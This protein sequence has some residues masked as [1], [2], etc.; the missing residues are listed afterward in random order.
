MRR[1]EQEIKDRARVDSIIRGSRVCRLGLSDQGQPYVVPLCFGYD[2]KA[3][4][5]HCAKEG[6]QLD[7]LRRNDKVC[8]EFDIVEGMVEADHGCNWGIRYQSIIGFGV[9]HLVDDATDKQKALT[10]LMAA[11]QGMKCSTFG[12]GELM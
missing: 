1:G 11:P 10:L 6:R 2:G 12:T 8:F 7:I 5:F 3:R 4:C 9:A